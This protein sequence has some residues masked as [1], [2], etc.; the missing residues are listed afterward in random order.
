MA[1]PSQS[2]AVAVVYCV[3]GGLI[4]FSGI[5]GATIQATASA[6]LK[7]NLNVT[8]TEPI[9]VVNSASTSTT[10]G[11]TGSNP[12]NVSSGAA[13]ANYLTIANY[14]VGQGYSK[15]AAAGI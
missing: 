13:S 12:G 2:K 10:I 7:G 8:N 4:L 6:V 15:A 3:A 9:N 1:S 11:A 14:L 5:K